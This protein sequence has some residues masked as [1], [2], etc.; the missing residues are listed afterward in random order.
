MSRLFSW[1]HAAVFDPRADAT[2][3]KFAAAVVA[4]DARAIWAVCVASLTLTQTQV[5]PP[6]G[7]SN[8]VWRSN[9]ALPSETNLSPH[10]PPA[11][12]RSHV[13]PGGPPSQTLYVA[14]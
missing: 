9:L 14:S 5:K 11:P 1:V 13:F 3:G 12:S 6:T 10:R 7:E 8:P 2:P 4:A